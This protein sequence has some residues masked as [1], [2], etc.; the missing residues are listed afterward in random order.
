[1]QIL[2]KFILLTDMFDDFD[3]FDVFKVREIHPKTKNFSLLTELLS[4]LTL[5]K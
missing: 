5:E 2:F 1:M 3:V 4:L